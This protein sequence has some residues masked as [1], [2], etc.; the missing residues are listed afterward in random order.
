MGSITDGASSLV[1]SIKEKTKK[2]LVKAEAQLQATSINKAILELAAQSGDEQE[3]G[4]TQKVLE[5][6][7]NNQPEASKLIYSSIQSRIKDKQDFSQTLQM[8]RYKA[9]TTA[10]SESIKALTEKGGYTPEEL[11]SYQEEVSNRAMK[12]AGLEDI[13]S[14]VKQSSM[15]T[16]PQTDQNEP[17]TSFLKTPIVGKKS[18]KQV[19]YEDSLKLGLSILDDTEKQYEE[20]SKKYGTGRLKGMKTGIQGK[21]GDLLPGSVQA[22]EVVPYMNNLE[23]L[24][25][26]IGK[27]VYKDERVS[28]VN[29]KGYKKALAELTNTPEEAKIMFA[30]LRR[31]AQSNSDS[32]RK[33]L[34]MMI[35]KDGE[36]KG[37]LPSEAVKK[38][39]SNKVDLKE[40]FS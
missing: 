10:V 24:A 7:G 2:D 19:D 16:A 38:S 3:L 8:E 35:P 5:A 40:L 21:M 18:D 30:T 32:D 9:A 23:G 27:T 39:E 34:R 20:I 31:Y 26:F 1:E 11:I 4:N 14:R 36:S 33:A 37:L 13:A 29:I 6:I 28:D 17:Q 12:A 25:N 15:A 22:P